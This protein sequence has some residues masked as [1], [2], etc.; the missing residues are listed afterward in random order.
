MSL[1][2][3]AQFY[4][5]NRLPIL[6]DV[7]HTSVRV[8][9]NGLIWGRLARCTEGRAEVIGH[10]RGTPCGVGAVQE[11]HGLPSGHLL[12]C[13]RRQRRPEEEAVSSAAGEDGAVSSHEGRQV[14]A[15]LLLKNAPYL[16]Q[17]VLLGKI[18]G[19]SDSCNA[20]ERNMLVQHDHKKRSKYAKLGVAGMTAPSQDGDKS[21][22]SAGACSS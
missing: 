9:I 13:Q 7:I 11:Q 2:K 20:S 22:L 14:G 8:N 18:M 19:L 16:W 3:R 15:V 1:D 4:E 10:T 17:S 12:A 21:T 5:L 6:A